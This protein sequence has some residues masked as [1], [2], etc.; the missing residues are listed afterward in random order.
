ML[1]LNQGQHL[2]CGG[3]FKFYQS[4]MLSFLETLSLRNTMVS[5]AVLQVFLF[6]TV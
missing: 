6:L 3:T 2:Y 4:T 5:Y 1:H